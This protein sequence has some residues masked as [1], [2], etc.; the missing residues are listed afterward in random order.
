MR[1]NTKYK[2]AFL[3]NPKCASESIRKLLDANSNI[4]SAIDKNIHHHSNYRDLEK[5]L[6][7]M[8]ENVNNYTVITTIRNPFERLASIYNYGL[9]KQNSVWHNPA[10]SSGAFK[11]FCYNTILDRAFDP[12]SAN[13]I[14]RGPYDIRT[15]GSDVNGVMKKIVIDVT[16]LYK[17]KEILNKLGVETGKIPHKNAYEQ[18]VDYKLLYDQEMINRVNKLFLVDIEFGNYKF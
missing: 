12:N 4:S 3:S 1:L 15:F 9:R 5:L 10:K 11:E 13:P 2:F 8:G 7:T 14:G 17:I 16:E 18:K 6:N